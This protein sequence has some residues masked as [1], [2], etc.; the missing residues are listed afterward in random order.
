MLRDESSCNTYNYSDALYWDARYVQEGGSFDWYQRYSSLCPFVRHF[1]PISS[2]DLMVGCGNAGNDG[3]M[4]SFPV[5]SE[6]MVKDGYEDIMNIDVSSVAIN[7]MISKYEHIPQLKY[8]QMDVRDMSFFPDDSFDGVIDK[9]TL[10]S[11]IFSIKLN[12]I[13]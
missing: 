2:S 1:I 8:M 9:G 6:D 10:D 12:W 4:F 3:K 13:P 7:M 5:M 11:L